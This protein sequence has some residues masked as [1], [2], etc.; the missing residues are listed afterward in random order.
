VFRK[1]DDDYDDYLDSGD[2]LYNAI[3]NNDE[4]YLHSKTT[5]LSQVDIREMIATRKAK[6]SDLKPIEPEELEK[7]RIEK[8]KQIKTKEILKEGASYLVFLVVILFIAYQSRSGFSYALHQDLSNTFLTH[9]EMN[10]EDVNL[11]I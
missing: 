6:L 3:I 4:E 7:Q 2:P 9:N 5:S 10:F 1:P 11:E 8:K